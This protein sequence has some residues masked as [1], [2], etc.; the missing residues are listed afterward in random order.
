MVVWAIV[1]SVGRNTTMGPA[2]EKERKKEDGVD[3]D[4]RDSGPSG[5]LLH[6]KSVG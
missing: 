1:C 4:M 6:A 2:D 3:M 5:V